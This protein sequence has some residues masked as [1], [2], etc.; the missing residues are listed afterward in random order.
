MNK[1]PNDKV[2]DVTGGLERIRF[3]L[4]QFNSVKYR[5]NLVDIK[6]YD[7]EK[8]KITELY[9]TPIDEKKHV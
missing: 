3:G 8:V 9:I 5:Y 1:F 6:F 7:E 4:I 2:C